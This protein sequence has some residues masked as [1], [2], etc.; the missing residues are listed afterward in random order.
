MPAEVAS[1]EIEIETFAGTVQ[2]SLVVTVKEAQLG[3]PV[4]A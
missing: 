3:N 1:T 4:Q 2:T